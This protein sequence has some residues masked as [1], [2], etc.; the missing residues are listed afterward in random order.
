MRERSGATQAVEEQQPEQPFNDDFVYGPVL[1]KEGEE[2]KAEKSAEV[3]KGAK[4]SAQQRGGA[5]VAGKRTVVLNSKR[6]SLPPRQP[7][8]VKRPSSSK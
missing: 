7:S 2:E 1:E 3:E 6:S 5:K 4:R 8:E